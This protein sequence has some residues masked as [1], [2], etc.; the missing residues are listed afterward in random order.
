LLPIVI[1]F[2]VVVVLR[3]YQAGKQANKIHIINLYKLILIKY[4]I[5]IERKSRKNGFKLIYGCKRAF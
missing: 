1:V 2:V 5:E 3:S 4:E